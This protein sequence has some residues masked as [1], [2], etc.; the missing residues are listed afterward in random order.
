MSIIRNDSWSTLNRLKKKFETN[1]KAGFL[2]EYP[3]AFYKN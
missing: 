3:K 1:Y 2:S